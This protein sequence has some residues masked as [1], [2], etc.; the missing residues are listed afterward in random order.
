MTGL[1]TVRKSVREDNNVFPYEMTELIRKEDRSRRTENNK[2]VYATRPE[3]WLGW[4][5]RRVV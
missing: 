1:V 5:K 3:R 4:M 2:A